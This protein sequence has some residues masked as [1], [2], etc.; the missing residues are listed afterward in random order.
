MRAPEHS[1]PDRDDQPD[2]RGHAEDVAT[3][4]MRGMRWSSAAI[5]LVILYGLELPK[6][7]ANWDTY[8]PVEVQLAALVVLTVV[9]AACAF[10]R[11]VRV[12][13]WPLIV[14][15]LAT[16]I[17]ATLTVAPVD[18]LGT[19]HW[20]DEIVGWPLVLLVMGKPVAMFAGLL[21]AHYVPAFVLA[22]FN[23]PVDVT[24]AG[25]V[26]TT[27]VTSAFQIAVILLAN[28]LRR[29]AVS[30]ARMSREEERA[31]TADA[32]A[33]Q[34]HADRK[35]RYAALAETTAPVLAGLAS[36]T[37]DPG[38]GTV[39]RTCA[40]EA[41]RMR[42]L[43][44][45]TTASPDPLVDE[46]MACVGLAERNGVSVR[47]SERGER[48]PVPVVMRRLLTEPAV[49]VLATARGNVRLTVVG[50][51]EEV[52]V[53]VVADSLPYD[54]PV[55]DN[56]EITTSTVTTGDRMWVQATWRG[57]G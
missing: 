14:V 28:A 13:R 55:V 15:V 34:L 22:I 38:D 21:V 56:D 10:D 48:P 45:E 25:A 43:F 29:V 16:S 27:V 12:F 9:S 50:A 52:T 51:G 54:V 40:I 23:G 41:A 7:L 26:N 6:L 24:F 39:R 20:S 35:D 46:L 18:R 5:S 47:F 11:V 42:R 2:V 49:A 8:R 17:A 3:R 33:S 32:V 30:V 57:R 53:S 31:R 4:Y 37:L 19:A 1:D 36:G 44:G